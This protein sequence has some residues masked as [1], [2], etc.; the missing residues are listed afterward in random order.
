MI[1]KPPHLWRFVNDLKLRWKLLVVV[2]PLA[3]VPALV[4]GTVVGYIAKQQAY[5]GITQTSKDDLEHMAQFAINLLASHHRQFEVYKQDKKESIDKELATLVNLAYN[6]VDAEE[7]QRRAGRVGLDAAQRE[8]SRALKSVN[9]GETGYL[10]AMTS[11]G[12]LVAHVA[13]EGENILD[14]RDENGRPFIREMCAAARASKPGEVL[15]TVYPWRNAALGDTH[16]R[17]KAVAYRGG[18]AGNGDEIG[19]AGRTHGTKHILPFLRQGSGRVRRRA[20]VHLGL[21]RRPDRESL[22]RATPHAR[23][24]GH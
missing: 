17:R 10:Y 22:Q 3:T 24:T 6:L 16:P 12:D 11:R 23:D 19:I 21:H 7:R 14:R 5:R 13:M 15:Y 18:E 8:A 1:L 2:L 4:V 20:G 9:V